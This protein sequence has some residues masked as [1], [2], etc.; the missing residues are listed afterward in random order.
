MRLFHSPDAVW[1]ALLLAGCQSAGTSSVADMQ[2]PR[3][4]MRPAPQEIHGDVRIDNYYW[5]NQREDP[6]VLAYLEAENAYLKAEL[7]PTEELQEQ[8][9]GEMVNRVSQDDS[10]APVRNGGFW[11][12]T[13]FEEG[14][15][16]PIL[17]RKRGFLS[18]DEQI[19]LNVNS[20][21]EGHGYFSVGDSEPS[22]DHTLLAYSTDDVGRR[23][24]D[25]QVMDLATGVLSDRIEGCTGAVVWAE[26]GKHLFYTRRDP[27]TLR[28]FQIWRHE[29]GAPASRDILVFEETDQEYSCNISKTRSKGYLV[30][31]SEQTL[32]TESRIL[33]AGNPTGDFRVVLPRQRGHEYHVDHHGDNLIFV[34]NH[35]SPNFKLMRAPVDTPSM[36]SW[37]EILPHRPDVLL[38][39][40]DLFRDYMVIIEREGGL[41]RR[42]VRAMADG[43]TYSIPFDDPT[44]AVSGSA[45][46]EFDTTTYRFSYS[47]P[48]TPQSVID[49]DM[50][51]RSQEVVKRQD[52][53]G[54][55][56]PKDYACE[57]IWATAGD[58][59][60]VPISLVYAK[61]F[62]KDG[63]QPLLLYGY[64]SYGSSINARFNPNILSLLDRGFVY[65]TAHVRGGQEMGRHWYEEGKLLNKRNTFTDFIACGE[66]L[67]SQGYTSP[68]RMSCMGGS[69][70]GLLIGAIINMR[71][72]LFHSAVAA[73]PFV[74]VVTT[75]LDA[76][77]PLTTFEW[78][79]WGN[80]AD[81]EYYEY[82]LS[83]S[84]YDQ[85]EAKDYPH[86]LITTGLHDSQVQYFEPAKWAAKLRE[87]KTD[88]NLLLMRCEM[89]AGHGGASGRY[90]RYRN[91]ALNYAFLIHTVGADP[92]P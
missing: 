90:D 85:V 19:L 52:I 48:V 68:E 5:L 70:G 76:T 64:G 67:V 47:S 32:A 17:C 69:A 50:A 41:P 30:I 27:Q 66:H 34:T 11:Y 65:A 54:D 39:D 14:Q 57:R 60:Q 58:G 87:L 22:P 53:L 51:T 35:E 62:A 61:P 78:D 86:L 77:I 31:S 71:P 15:S 38:E 26:D 7:A 21:A 63:T 33:E 36:D 23:I 45:N 59:T 72:D 79:E 2:A 13:R 10:T 25:L 55:Y 75:M 88:D 3:A 1:L 80:P 18:A 16:Y 84:P 4:A 73:V 92:E 89:E 9:F 83:Y 28:A 8:L 74:D 42:R 20:L 56:D 49:F 24:Y 40:V 12:Y 44:Y 82:M 37:V 6:E 29:L 43:K 91:T 81:P 46:P